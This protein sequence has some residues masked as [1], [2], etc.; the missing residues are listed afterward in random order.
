MI[1]RVPSLLKNQGSSAV[2]TTEGLGRKG[3]LLFCACLFSTNS[4]LNLDTESTVGNW[5]LD[6]H[7]DQQTEE[8]P[9]VMQNRVWS[10]VLIGDGV[11]GVTV[12]CRYSQGQGTDSPETLHC[13]VSV[14]PGAC[15]C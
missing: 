10:L 8:I 5:D 4:I 12:P 15:P 11:G 3:L 13:Q 14:K 6:I 7:V 9:G 2:G 1:T